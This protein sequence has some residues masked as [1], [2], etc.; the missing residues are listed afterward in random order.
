M[1]IT[2]QTQISAAEPDYHQAANHW[3]QDMALVKEKQIN[4]Y[5]SVC[6][7]LFA[8]LALSIMC[9]TSLVTRESV[10][11]FLALMDKRTGEVTT[12]IRLNAQANVVNWNMIRHFVT[13]YVTNREAYNFLNINEP[14]QSLMAMSNASVKTQIDQGLRPELNPQSPIKVLGQH[15]YMTVTIHSISKLNSENLLDIRFTTHVVNSET[16][17]SEQSKAW[18]V[19][20]KWELINSK[21]SMSEWD[22]N[23]LGFTVN[24]YDKQPVLS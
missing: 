14:Y 22:T 20:M 13:R 2:T 23:P 24:F 21:R 19:T 12:P 7:G 11:P 16:N 15:H 1:N 4:L 6:I 17:K 10:Q 5:R 8:L 3:Y 9:V 18:R